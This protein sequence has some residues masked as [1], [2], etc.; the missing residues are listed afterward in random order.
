V[1]YPFDLLLNLQ[2]AAEA[3]FPYGNISLWKFYDAAEFHSFTVEICSPAASALRLIAVSPYEDHPR[4]R[5]FRRTN[6]TKYERSKDVSAMKK[7][8][9]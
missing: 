3:Y 9:K 6:S 1:H 4:P 5:G 7:K 2:F 8:G